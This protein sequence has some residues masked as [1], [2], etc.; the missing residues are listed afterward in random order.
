LGQPNILATLPKTSIPPD[1]HK[2]RP[3]RNPTVQVPITTAHNLDL[4]WVKWSTMAEVMVSIKPNI[5][6]IPNNLKSWRLKVSLF[7]TLSSKKKRR[8]GHHPSK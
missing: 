4:K 7:A 3:N 8:N 5:E 6:S 2:V 1:V